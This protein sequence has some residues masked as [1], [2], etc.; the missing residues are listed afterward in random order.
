[1]F[2]NPG[3]FR[4]S[5]LVKK[6][7]AFL[8]I[9]CQFN[10]TQSSTALTPQDNLN[11]LTG[12]APLDNSSTEFAPE[13]VVEEKTPPPVPAPSNTTSSATM[14]VEVPKGSDHK[15][16]NNNNNNNNNVIVIDRPP[17]RE[18]APLP[19][20]PPPQPEP[21]REEPKPE[22]EPQ[23]PPTIIQVLPALP[24]P[25][26]RKEPEPAPEP[27]KEEP[28]PEPPK[29][30]PKSEPKPEPVEEIIVE[31]ELSSPVIEEDILVEITQEEDPL[32]DFFRAVK[33]DD[34]VTVRKYLEE[35]DVW[36]KRTNELGQLPI[37]VA[38]EGAAVKVLSVLLSYKANVN[39]KDRLKNSAL[40]IA[41]LQKDSYDHARFAEALIRA[42][43]KA[44]KD[45]I[46]AYL[47]PVLRINGDLFQKFDHNGETALHIASQRDQAGFVLLFLQK[48]ISVRTLDSEGSTPLHA[49]V[50]GRA[51]QAMR[52]LLEA[53]ADVNTPD[54]V[55][56]MPL[57]LAFAVENPFP[58][59]SLL[60]SYGA[61]ANA[62]NIYGNTPLIL[63][64]VYNLDS[65][66]AIELMSYRA[67]INARNS[68]GDYALLVAVKHSNIDLAYFLLNNGADPYMQNNLGQ[69]AASVAATMGGDLMSAFNAFTNRW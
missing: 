52:I 32:D 23:L 42:G 9:F 31:D 44:P 22:P 67:K 62:P 30:E 5:K 47:L 45:E 65:R 1:M 2:K 64:A 51:L 66:V 43:S 13:P 49:A 6:A 36:V 28:K 26:E 16:N 63:V 57:H 11:S 3:A 20:P 61:D 34:D 25:P 55:Q 7:W 60:L 58:L 33:E 41:L 27:P 39:A 10:I 19:P 69:S 53:G 21:K 12:V 14:N 68:Y 50:Q 15:S 48:G 4:V 8:F 46:F 29:K 38:A 59:I 24:L 40:D 54:Y 35:D 37:H 56:S 18:A 17:V